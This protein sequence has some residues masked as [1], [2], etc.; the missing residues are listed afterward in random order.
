MGKKKAISASVAKARRPA[1]VAQTLKNKKAK[2]AKHA[3]L[4]PNDAQV[5]L[6]KFTERKRPLN[7]GTAPAEN[8]TKMYRD[9]AGNVKG[10]LPR[11]APVYKVA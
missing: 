11:F 1:K 10:G 2:R 5:S 3:K 4:H 6:G 7:K 8:R 9:E